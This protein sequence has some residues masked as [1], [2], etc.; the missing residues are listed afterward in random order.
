MSKHTPGPWS[1]TSPKFQEPVI[2]QDPCT[3]I[4]TVYLRDFSAGAYEQTLANAAAIAAV[5]DLL[6]ACDE[7]ETAFA[8]VQLCDH[9]SPQAR[10]AVIDARR[11]CQD[12]IAK[13][14]PGSVFAAAVAE[15]RQREADESERLRAA[16]SALL[17]V[18][19]RDK[20]GSFFICTEAEQ[21][22]VDAISVIGL[23]EGANGGL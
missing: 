11:I 5:P 15:V 21:V 18:I 20:D 22:V 14:R 8:V 16:L 3:P 10:S 12:A 9:L 2:V 1:H 17:F 23:R 13:A 4:A 6:A 19:N 7:A